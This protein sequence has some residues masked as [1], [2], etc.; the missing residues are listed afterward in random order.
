MIGNRIT[1]TSH[2]L[3]VTRLI[4]IL[5]LQLCLFSLAIPVANA[6]IE[7]SGNVSG[8]IWTAGTYLVTSDLTVDDKTTLI[9]EAG[10]VVKFQPGLRLTINGKLDVNGAPG[11]SVIF[12]SRDDDIFGETIPGSD[13]SPAPGDWLAIHLYGGYG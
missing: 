8:Q 7:K 4:V 3:S 11:N 5:V 13:G 10:A 9:I 2:A 12:T 6:Y 1:I